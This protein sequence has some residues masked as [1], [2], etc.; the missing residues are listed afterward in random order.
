MPA[1][2]SSKEGMT[3]QP[4]AF[5]APFSTPAESMAR[6]AFTQLLWALSYPGRIGRLTEVG[7]ATFA[8][9]LIVGQTLL[10][11][12]TSYF[13]PDAQL[14]QALARSGARR[15][16]AAAAAYHF[17]PDLTSQ[18]QRATLLTHARDAQV[19]TLLYPDTAATLII[20]CRLGTGYTLRLRGPG[21]ATECALAVAGVPLAFWQLRAERVIYPIGWDLLFI[22]G[23]QVVGLPRTTVIQVETQAGEA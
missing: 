17:Y 13:T 7:S 21:I 16:G 15:A 10:D 14:D 23:D 18:A 12:E 1:T 22:D 20:G 4:D 8:S 3:G 6:T 2:R 5:P 9:C 11:L 19:G